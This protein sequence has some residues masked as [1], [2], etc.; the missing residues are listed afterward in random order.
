MSEM[1]NW[2]PNSGVLTVPTDQGEVQGTAHN[3][4]IYLHPYEHRGADHIFIQ[5]GEEDS[6][7]MGVFVLRIA[8][9]VVSDNFDRIVTEMTGCGFDTIIADR[10]AE[11]DKVQFDK[12]VETILGRV[13]LDDLEKPWELT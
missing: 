8:S 2:N 1:M 5:T 11:C 10:V 4:T 3:A 12:T 13:S 6:Q 9:D 7:V